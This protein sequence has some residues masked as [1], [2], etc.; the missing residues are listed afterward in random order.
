MEDKNTR[1]YIEID[2]KNK[3][4]IGSGYGDRFKLIQEPEDDVFI[5]IFITKGQYNKL[6]KQGG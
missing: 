5:R 1:Y 3:K 6:K 2:L 4:I